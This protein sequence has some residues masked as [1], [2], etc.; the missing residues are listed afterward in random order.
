[1]LTA[2]GAAVLS[3]TVMPAKALA[4]AAAMLWPGN[5]LH[6]TL[7]RLAVDVLAASTSAMGPCTSTLTLVTLH[8]HRWV[9]LRPQLCVCTVV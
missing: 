9:V 3:G 6:D 8:L 2:A 1:M 5:D 4:T 7:R